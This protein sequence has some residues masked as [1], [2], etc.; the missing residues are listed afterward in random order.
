MRVDDARRG[1]RVAFIVENFEPF[2]VVQ[3][4]QRLDGYALEAPH[5]LLAT[6]GKG[7]LFEGHRQTLGAGFVLARFRFQGSTQRGSEPAPASASQMREVLFE[8]IDARVWL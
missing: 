1:T 5:V 2:A 4:P 6:M 8:G 7:G 3:G